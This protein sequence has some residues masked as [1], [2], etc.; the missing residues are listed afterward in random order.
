MSVRA[1]CKQCLRKWGACVDPTAHKDVKAFR[2]DFRLG[3]VSGQRYRPIFDRREDAEDYERT[4]VTDFKRGVLFPNTLGDKRTFGQACDYYKDTY[5]IPNQQTTDLYYLEMFREWFGA[6][7]LLSKIDQDKCKECFASLAARMQPASV[8][9]RWSL[10]I[11]V[12]RENK[13]WCPN[14][15]ARGVIPRLF[16]KK[17]D[18]PKPVYFADDEYLKL[19]SVVDRI[20]DEDVII[21]F[22]NTGFRKADGE[23]FCVEHCDFTTN[24]IFVPEQKNQE[25]GTIPMVP[26]VRKRVLEIMKRRGITSGPI[27]NMANITRRF[28]RLVV[29]AGLYKPYPNNKTLH[30]LRHSWGTYVQKNYK[31]IATTQKLMRQKTI[32]MTMRYV[33]AA[34]DLLKSA[35]LAGSA[36]TAPT[37]GHNVD[38]KTQDVAA[39]V[40]KL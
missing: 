33:H 20:E 34:D 8:V 10:L 25:A 18:R 13:K 2:A 15:P 31:D 3:G 12:F 14:N 29:K 26:E 5:L 22:R 11:S 28:R 1:W 24:T 35:A 36:P 27:L 9:R 7:T 17:A 40:E 6:N 21:I 32:R 38:T 30:S 4:T 39:P 37:N 16:R 23:N 19:L